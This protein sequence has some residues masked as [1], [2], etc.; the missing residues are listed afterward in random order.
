MSTTSSYQPGQPVPTA[1]VPTGAHSIT[2]HNGHSPR[3]E[4]LRA[5]FEATFRGYVPPEWTLD[6][7]CTR[8]G[9]DPELF[10][11]SKGGNK[12]YAAV[13]RERAK[14]ICAACIVR[15][16][17]LEDALA[18]ETGRTS[19]DDVR[20]EVHGFRAG[21]TEKERRSMVQ[22]INADAQE[23]LREA[24]VKDYVDNP[25]RLVEEIAA[26][27]GVTPNSVSRW[28][29]AAGVEVR[30]RGGSARGRSGDSQAAI[31]GYGRRKGE[32]TGRSAS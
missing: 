11:P 22:Q 1:P 7:E 23:K 27:H 8:P 14:S 15:T 31:L 16:E 28:A 10:F 21:L 12:G 19:G 6:A 30:A 18:F 2:H 5:G 9:T 32:T 3:V 13:R 20:P 24:V 25:H 4:G 26:T 17:C 29:K